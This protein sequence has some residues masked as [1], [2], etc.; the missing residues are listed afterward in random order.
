MYF[1]LVTN[2][3]LKSQQKYLFFY[4]V[5]VSETHLP[6]TLAFFFQ[7]PALLSLADEPEL[8]DVMFRFWILIVYSKSNPALL[9]FHCGRKRNFGL[10]QIVVDMAGLM[11][12]HA[13]EQNDLRLFNLFPVDETFPGSSVTCALQLVACTTDRRSFLDLIMS[14]LSHV[15]LGHVLA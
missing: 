3:V 13:R 8:I 15:D 10:E 5:S 6:G 4:D 7:N 12:T 1:A 9:V 14:W 11:R 2:F